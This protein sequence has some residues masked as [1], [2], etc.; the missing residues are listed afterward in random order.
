MYLEGKLQFN[1]Q[2]G[3]IIIFKWG[4]LR[5]EKMGKAEKR[6]ITQKKVKKP[7]FPLNTPETMTKGDIFSSAN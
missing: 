3:E 7:P 2:E 5:K 1:G 6:I 4:K